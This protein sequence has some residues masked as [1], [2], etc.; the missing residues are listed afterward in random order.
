MNDVTH[1][2]GQIDTGD[3]RPSE[4]LLPLV[5][6]QLRGLATRELRREP[7][8]V[9]LQPTALVHEAF[10]R[11]VDQEEKPTWN[12]RGHF[13]AAAAQAMRRILVENARRK[14][15]LKRGRDHRRVPIEAAGLGDGARQ[16]DLIALDDALSALDEQKPEIAQLVSLRFFAGL[17]MQEAAKSMRIS[18]RTAERRWTYA[19]AWLLAAMEDGVGS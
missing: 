12:H 17:T 4:D 11:L 15:T 3:A 5:Y 6:D 1:M 2:L 18:V 7:T 14:N 8:G 9:T 16:P 10:V 19:K 13:F